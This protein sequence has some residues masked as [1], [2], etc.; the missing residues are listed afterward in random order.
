MRSLNE[1]FYRVAIYLRL[2]RD[3][4]NEESQS[5][6]SQR[7]LLTAYVRKQGWFLIDEYVDDGY[8]GTNFDRPSF[9]RLIADIE[10]GKI[11]MVVTKD[12]SRL[13]RHYIQVGYYTEEY[14]PE[15]NVRY[16]ALTDNYDT[17]KDEGNDFAPFKNVI[18][19]WYA[20]D[21][22]K[23]I[24]SILDEKAR[25]GEPRNTAIPIFGYQYNAAF[26]RVPDSETGPIVQL[27]FKKLIEL[28]STLRV[29][30]Y[31]TAHK[32][33]T[34]RY[35]NAIKYGYNKAKI[36]ALPESEWYRWARGSVRD[37]IVREEYLGVYKTAQSKS[38]SYKN[39]RRFGNQ[40]CYVFEGR[41]EPLVDKST[42]ELANKMLRV[43]Q[44]TSIPIQENCF[45]GLLY[46]ADC[47][48]VLRLE[49]KTNLRK[50]IYD[51]RYYCRD[52]NCKQSNTITKSMLESAV[53]YE[54]LQMRDYILSREEEFL[55]FAAQFD[56]KGRKLQTDIEA[57]LQK[58]MLKSEE[59]NNY[60]EKLFENNVKGII[61]ASTFT[62]MMNKYKKEKES[63][64]GTIRV[65]TRRVEEENRNPQNQLRAADFI[66]TLKGLND[67][68]IVE[69]Y[70][71]Q[72]L[73]KKIIVK[74][75]RINNSVKNREICLTIQYYGNDE[76]MNGFLNYGE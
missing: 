21:T 43:T 5:I 45:K 72:K 48:R 9:K 26:E 23:K 57:D 64:E 16:I 34:A 61:P 74:T 70:I 59:I 40:D 67:T 36:L 54:I 15:H 37:I 55:K 39:K 62:V 8:T 24:R 4:G 20:R 11:D 7:E 35:Y 32:I 22:S 1:G 27:I 6:Q 66:N 3:D 75:R 30:E 63:L 33:K 65:L 52:G 60:I 44:G 31:L 19:E 13:G 47:G 76:I 25:R 58:A 71:I 12:L 56:T 29:E 28:G 50:Q 42:W 10:L 51:Y 41:Y 69:P 14:F 46:C 73:I 68:N 2:S 18:N 53:I 38:V 49:R 17:E